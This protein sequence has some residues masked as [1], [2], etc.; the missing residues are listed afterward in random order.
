MTS[1]S[2]FK[3]MMWKNLICRNSYFD[4]KKVYVGNKICMIE[5]SFEEVVTE[6]KYGKIINKS[7]FDLRRIGNNYPLFPTNFSVEDAYNYKYHVY[8]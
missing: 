8:K 3:K 6:E 5:D 2:Q 1:V 4:I 7:A